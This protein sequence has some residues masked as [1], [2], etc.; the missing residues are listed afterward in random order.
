MPEFKR[1]CQGLPLPIRGKSGNDQG[2]NGKVGGK[3]GKVRGK[4]GKPNRSPS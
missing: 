4:G 2:K 3:N 1:V